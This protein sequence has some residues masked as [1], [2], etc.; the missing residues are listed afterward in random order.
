[1][2]IENCEM[3]RKTLIHFDKPQEELLRGLLFC[4]FFRKCAIHNFYKTFEFES[5]VPAIRLRE[6]IKGGMEGVEGVEGVEGM[7]YEDYVRLAQCIGVQI[8]YLEQLGYTFYTLD[9]DNI[10]V[11]CN[12]IYIYIG[13]DYLKKISEDGTT[14]SF[15]CP[16]EKTGFLS[17]EITEITILPCKVDYR[18]VYHSLASLILSL[19]GKAIHDTKLHSFIQRCM[20][21]K[22]LFL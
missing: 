10:L 21:H 2:K 7:K 19:G 14:I 13:G 3:K 16:F 8:F 11:V 20:K 9:L 17:K 22:I 6:K 5:D 15:T 1:M 18:C 4:K 12:N